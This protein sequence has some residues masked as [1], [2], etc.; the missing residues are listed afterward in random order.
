MTGRARVLQGSFEPHRARCSTWALGAVAALVTLA[1]CGTVSDALADATDAERKFR[2]ARRLAAEGSEQALA[3]LDEV[4]RADPTGA[5][6]D[7]ALVERA[8]LLGAAAFPERAGSMSVSDREAA[9]VALD[10]VRTEL[11][12]AD[13]TPEAIVR[14]AL[15]D[16]EPLPGRDDTS[17]RSLLLEVATSESAGEWAAR[18]RY[19]LGWLDLAAGDVRAARGAWARVVLDHPAGEAAVRAE[20][21]L[22]RDDLRAGRFGLAA[23]RFDR[24]VASDGAA[25]EA[26]RPL[27]ELS[28]RGALRAAGAGGTWGEV[29]KPVA[30]P[31][32]VR[33]V[34][35]MVPDGAGA[36]W[37]A[38]RRRGL[39]Q[40][41]GSERVSEAP[42]S[43]EEVET[44]AIDPWGRLFAALGARVARVEGGAVRDVADTR[45]I[46]NVGALAIDRTGAIW[47]ASRKG[48]TIGVVSPGDATVAATIELDDVRIGALA[49]DGV[50][51]LGLDIRGGAVVELLADGSVRT[52]VG[53]LD[54]PRAFAVDAAGQIAV[55][56]GKVAVVELFGPDG[57]RR[58]RIVCAE[59]GVSRVEGMT[60]GLDGSLDLFDAAQDR[61]VRIP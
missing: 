26:A 2:V 36:T 25:A 49:F 35:A 30:F 61:V 59:Y 19:A 50:R 55:L 9:R 44:I 11:V 47:T 20:L 23:E 33:S 54:R 18:A 31:V 48:D 52:I 22:G 7:D 6:A 60:L 39:L 34:G 5:L 57:D 41:V 29:G 42:W 40:R 16:L 12:D 28:V 4:V 37:V 46:G 17:A 3:A 21:A 1:V 10:R 13:R 14:R 43:V 24:V 15:L 45:V 53:G 32:D 58:D 8:M 27:R 56:S 51:R 38:D